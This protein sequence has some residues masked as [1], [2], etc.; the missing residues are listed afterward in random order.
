MEIFGL[1]SAVTGAAI[2]LGALSL[3]G[4]LIRQIGP[5]RTII[6]QE[7]AQFRAN[8]IATNEALTRR[9]VKVEKILQRERAIRNAERMLD[10]HK[11]TN[12]TACLDSAIRMLEMNPD[13]APEVV[14]KIK[15]M[16]ATQM[17][18]EAQEAAIIHA[19]EI[20]ADETSEADA[21]GEIV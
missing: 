14:E 17:I 18:A 2:I 19:A 7:E 1:P 15:E 6:I 9:I 12:L 20:T 21:Q 5:W 3:F 13:R 8:L 4:L 10:R 16:R 11:V